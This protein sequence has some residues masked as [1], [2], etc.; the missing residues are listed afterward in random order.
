MLR[1][2]V[3]LLVT[4]A[5]GGT[6]T[7]AYI[8]LGGTTNIGSATAYYTPLGCCPVP[9]PDPS[10]ISASADASAVTLGQIRNGFIQ[11][12]LGFFGS[13]PP[14]ALVPLSAEIIFSPS[15]ENLTCHSR[16]GFLL[17]WT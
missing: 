3:L 5:F 12:S 13:E 11:V 14:G 9:A 1:F 4:P 15:P 8:S 16:W 7:F 17:K 6:V 2:L 10:F